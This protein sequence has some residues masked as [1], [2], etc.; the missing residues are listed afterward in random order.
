[1]NNEKLIKPRKIIVSRSSSDSTDSIDVASDDDESIKSLESYHEGQNSSGS[2]SSSVN[3]L[4]FDTGSNKLK[5][6]QKKRGSTN[7]FKSIETADMTAANVKNTP[8]V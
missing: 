1:M 4:Q 8:M 2:S 3:E 7:C 5:T 6:L